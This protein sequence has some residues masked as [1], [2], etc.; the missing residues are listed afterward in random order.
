MISQKIASM[1]VSAT[2][3]MTQKARDLRAKGVDVISLSVGEPD[4]DTPEFIKLAAKRAMDA[5][6]TKYTAVDGIAELK[7]AVCEKFFRENGLV[8]T[9]SQINV[10]PGGKAVL[11][12]AFAATLDPGD[13][14]LIPAPCWVS[15]PDMVKMLG[16]KPVIL[17]TDLASEF[18][19]TPEQLEAGITDRCKWLL[20]NSPSNPTGSVYSKTELQALGAVISRYPNVMVLTDEIY[21]HL[22]YEG[23]FVS[24]AEANP[25]LHDR[26]LTMNGVSKAYA[27]TGWR[28]GYAGG[29]EPVIRSMAKV[30]TQTTSNPCS[31]SQWAAE[32]ALNGDQSFLKDRLA[33]F[34]ERR[35]FVVSRL[36]EIPELKCTSPGGAFYVFAEADKCLGKTSAGGQE[37]QSDVDLCMALLSEAHIAV[38]PGSAFKAPGHFRLSYA[39][40]MPSLE[41]AMNRLRAFIRDLR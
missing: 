40:D 6:H 41:T 9:A 38:V 5:G 31:I 32:A 2:M 1:P 3:A 20:L 4:F 18:K 26:T 22:V 17:E 14:V 10:S 8:Y 28:I 37:I 33:A 39:T 30:M 12:N 29:P 7:Q 16:G 24:F 13:E 23:E 11:Y 19:I 34:R 15:Y 25:D 36:S 35:D 27:M 21:E